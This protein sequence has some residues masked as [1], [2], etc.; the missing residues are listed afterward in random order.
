VFPSIYP[1]HLL[2]VPFGGKDFV[3]LCRLVQAQAASYGVPVRRAG[4]LPPASFRLRLA[5]DALALS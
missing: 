2:T 5:A 1:P 3:L 4:G